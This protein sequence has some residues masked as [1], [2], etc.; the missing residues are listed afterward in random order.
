ML[1]VDEI[2]VDMMSKE[3]GSRPFTVK[4]GSYEW[5]TE[6]VTT[7]G[8]QAALIASEVSDADKVQLVAKAISLYPEEIQKVH[9]AMKSFNLKLASSVDVIAYHNKAMVILD[10]GQ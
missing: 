10:N 8:A 1:S 2:V 9:P 5:L 4:A 7:F 3:F 6:D